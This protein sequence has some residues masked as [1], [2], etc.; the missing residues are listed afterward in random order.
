MSRSPFVQVAK[1]EDEGVDIKNTQISEIAC[2]NYMNDLK[3]Q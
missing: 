3:L 2:R 1:N